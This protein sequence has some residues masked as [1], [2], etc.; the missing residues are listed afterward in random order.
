MPEFYANEQEY[1]ANC[2]FWASVEKKLNEEYRPN[3]WLFTE[4]YRPNP[5]E[6]V[7]VITFHNFDRSQAI[8]VSYNYRTDDIAISPA[9]PNRPA[10]TPIL[11]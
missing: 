6:P 5:R 7:Y 1:K 2:A 10:R 8:V 3:P 4:A 9:R 11:Y